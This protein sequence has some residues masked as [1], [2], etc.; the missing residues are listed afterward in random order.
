MKA[1]HKSTPAPSA[2][3][4]THSPSLSAVHRVFDDL[5][6]RRG[7]DFA[8]SLALRDE[9]ERLGSENLIQARALCELLFDRLADRADL[10]A[11]R[12][13]LAARH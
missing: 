1:T 10:T 7:Q 11:Y 5:E 9:L 3:A 13:D 6:E 2:G 12:S 4:V 8:L